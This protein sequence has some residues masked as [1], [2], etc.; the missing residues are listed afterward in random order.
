[1]TD[2]Q[3]NDKEKVMTVP[4]VSDYLRIPVSTIYDLT[5]KGKIR[6]VKVGRQWRYL[7][8]DIR[9]F[10]HGET[11]ASGGSAR[12]TEQRKHS[13]IRTRIPAQIAVHLG[14]DSHLKK[15]GRLR[16]ISEGGVLFVCEN[17]NGSGIKSLGEGQPVKIIFEIAGNGSSNKIEVAG[18]IVHFVTNGEVKTGI[19]FQNLSAK[20]R[21]AIQDYVG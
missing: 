5:H 8:A 18:R 3:K 6:G 2:K 12:L 21:E 7:E 16:D 4:E 1:M 15:N 20:D 19:Q 17:G 11:L 9:A 13:R 10:L 14:E